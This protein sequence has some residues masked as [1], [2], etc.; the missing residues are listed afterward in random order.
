MAKSKNTYVGFE[1]DWLEKKAE[2]LRIS[3]DSNPFNLLTDRLIEK[4][5]ARG[6]VEEIAATIEDQR[7]S[8]IQALKDYAQIIEVINNL[9]EKE[10]AKIESRGD[11]EVSSLA[12][13]FM[14]DR[15]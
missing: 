10:Q 11:Q 4:E 1:L 3:V 7:K 6:T 14:I 9:R 5:T 8:L 12:K 13:K 15:K 2:E